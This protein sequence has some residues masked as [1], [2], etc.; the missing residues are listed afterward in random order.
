MVTAR[1]GDLPVRMEIVAVDG[2]PHDA[3]H[4]PHLIDR[5]G[6]GHISSEPPAESSRPVRTEGDGDGDV[7]PDRDPD[8]AAQPPTSHDGGRTEKTEE[9]ATA[10]RVADDTA[11]QRMERESREAP[12]RVLKSFDD[13]AQ[14]LS[15]IHI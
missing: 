8:D 6:A 12:A 1:F 11:T 15:L 7:V 14:K 3:A 9:L 13:A 2:L 4:L 5:D 10:R